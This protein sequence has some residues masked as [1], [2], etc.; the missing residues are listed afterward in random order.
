M[1]EPDAS[2]KFADNLSKYRAKRSPDRSPE[3]VGTVSPV[4]GNLF[5]VHKHAA[6]QLHFDL[7]LEMDGVLRSWAV[8]KGPSL[9]MSDKRLAVKVEDHPLEY[10]DF[11]GVI[12]EGN[13]GAGGVIVWDRGQWVPLEDWRTGLEKGKLLFEL[14]GYKLRGK[15]TLVKIKKSER[16]WLLIKER[17]SYMKQPGDQFNEESVLSGLTVEEIIAGDTPAAR[18]RKA[19][20]ATDAPRVRVDP[21]SVEPMHAESADEAFTRDGWIF[22]LKL[23]G[24]R[25]IASKSHGE[26]LLLTRNGNDYTGVF[27]EI[28]RAVKALPIDDCIIDG[29]VVVC[30][31]KGL[32]SFAMLQRRGRLTSSM[33]IKRAAV[34]LPAT[35][36]SFDFLAFEDFDLRP[37]PLVERKQQLMEVLPKLGPLRALEH[38]ETDGEAFLEQVTAMGLEG[39]IAKKADS[40]YRPRR[41]SDWLKIKAE[42]TGD[43]IIV[44]F[45]APKRSRGYFGALQLADMVNGELVY[46]GRVGTGFNQAL[47]SELKE[48][49]DGIVR[50]DPPCAGPSYGPGIEPLPSDD[51]LE[52]STTTWVDPV[53][54]CEVRYREWT[55]DGLLRHSAFLRMRDDKRPD[56][57]ERQGWTAVVSDVEGEVAPA[58]HVSEPPPPPPKPVVEKKIA[59]SNLNKVFWPAEEYTKGDLIE[60]Y[61]SVSK[62][63]LPYLRNRPVVLTRFP[64]GIDG[65]SFY[66]KDAPEFAPDWI[67]TVPIWSEETQRDIRYFVCDDEESL[68]YLANM[69][70]IP[71][72]IWG[73]R[74]G[75]LE[76]PDWCVIDLDPKDAPF[77]HVIRVAQVLHR[78]CDDAGLPNYVKTTGKTGLHVMIPLGRQLTYEQCR[79]LGELL[80]RVVLRECADIATITRH[81]NRRGDKVYL[82]YL[83]NRHGQLIVS[84]FSVRP[85]PGATV[86]M[87]L[88]WHDVDESLDPRAF[89]IR[90]SID[91]MHALDTDPVV[92][93]I[94]AKPNL[95]SVLELLTLALA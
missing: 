74:V 35:F 84:P 62:W 59:F 73:S 4:P 27:P 58:V 76:L 20:E 65:K 11:E 48:M 36:Y 40:K 22:E 8:P 26:A 82:D 47:L 15:W 72:H 1:M 54:V 13:Y 17:D 7:R 95:T 2:E 31:A 38:I 46:A 23:D 66:Q 57:C 71:L 37:L 70:T 24:Y 10:G 52:T 55:Q 69:G 45:T 12:P 87:P 86:S 3:P 81:I 75:S 56:E 44:G 83:Q 77:S 28:A 5:V 79:T 64:D 9:D 68:L 6:R 42:R 18:L 21:R 85:L 91:R 14:N 92:A 90:T 32:P 89:T 43:F 30:D 49:L 94:E 16:D 19:L 34:D 53:Y 51:I 39:I 41:S 50:R 25:L 93:V 61:R 63:I 88:N 67:R 78:I 80:A 29:E 33:D 60:Y